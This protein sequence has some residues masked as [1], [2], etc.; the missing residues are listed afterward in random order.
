MMKTKKTIP[1][2]IKKKIIPMTTVMYCEL[3][4][5]KHAHKNQVRRID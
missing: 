5:E 2:K 3:G 1:L 4:I